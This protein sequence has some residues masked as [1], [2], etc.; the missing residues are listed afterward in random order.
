LTTLNWTIKT[1]VL[2]QKIPIN[3]V[4]ENYFIKK[5]GFRNNHMS[6]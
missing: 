3:A 6:Q 2:L 1:F 5:L 4:F